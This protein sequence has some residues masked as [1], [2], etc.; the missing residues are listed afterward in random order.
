MEYTFSNRRWLNK[1]DMENGNPATEL[2]GLGF[3]VPRAFD[4]VLQIKHC[5]LQEDTANRIR[6]AI[7]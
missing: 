4:K 1:A 5:H 3:H 6:N 2:R 7:Y